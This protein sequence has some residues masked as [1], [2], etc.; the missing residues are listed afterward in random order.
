MKI[1]QTMYIYGIPQKIP[2][3]T[4]HHII[5]PLAHVFIMSLQDEEVPI[6]WK[7][8]NL[9]PLLKKGS[10]NKSIHCRPVGGHQ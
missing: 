5:M 1:S 3:E 2:K 8:A 4:V 10:R 6:E 7:E 9:I